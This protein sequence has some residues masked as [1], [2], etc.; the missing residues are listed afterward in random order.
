MLGNRSD[1]PAFR[2]TL[3]VAPV[4]LLKQWK[5]EIERITDHKLSVFIHHGKDKAK[6]EKQFKKYDV[7]VTSTQVSHLQNSLIIVLLILSVLN[8]IDSRS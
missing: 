1:D 5:S 2:T 4:S 8:N 6:H 3:V 7:V